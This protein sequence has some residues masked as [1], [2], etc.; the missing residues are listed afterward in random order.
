ME[1]YYP[2]IPDFDNP[3]YTPTPKN[4]LEIKYGKILGIKFF[5][6][7]LKN[8]HLWQKEYSSST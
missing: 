1:K 2:D 8:H 3:Y 6:Y 4:I 5:D 7:I